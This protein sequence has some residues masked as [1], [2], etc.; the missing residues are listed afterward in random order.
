VGTL[1]A[2]KLAPRLSQNQASGLEVLADSLVIALVSLGQALAGPAL[3][4][5][6]DGFVQSVSRYA[7]S[8]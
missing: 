3:A 1:P 6:P 4:V 2:A 5:Q 8:S 7:L